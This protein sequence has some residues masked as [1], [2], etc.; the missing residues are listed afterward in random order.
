MA[1][2]NLM[3]PTQLFSRG[4]CARVSS[5]SNKIG[6]HG[7]RSTILVQWC[8]VLG[9]PWSIW[10]HTRLAYHGVRVAPGKSFSVLLGV[11]LYTDQ[12]V[13][14]LKVRAC[15]NSSHSALQPEQQSNNVLSINDKAPF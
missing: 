10:E 2:Q 13:F 5:K 8:R 3:V 9:Q 6:S 14:D 15:G 11:L 4:S 1:S 12:I 7:S